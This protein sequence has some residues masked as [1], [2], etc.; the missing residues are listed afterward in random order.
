MKPCYAN[1]ASRPPVCLPG[2]ARYLVIGGDMRARAKSV[3]SLVLN[4]IYSGETSHLH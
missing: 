1:K 4:V 2:M 3:T